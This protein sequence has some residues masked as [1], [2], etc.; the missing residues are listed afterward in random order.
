MEIRAGSPSEAFVEV[1]GLL[2][3]AP[4]V[5]PRALAARELPERL[6]VVVSRPFG[7]VD[8]GPG[9]RLNHAI[10]VVEGLSLVGQCSVPELQ[11]DRVKALS[12]FVN[13]G[14][15]RGA[16]GSRVEGRLTDAVR[17]L[18]RD[19]FSRQAVLSIYDSHRDLGR[20]DD[21]S[22]SGDVPCTVAVQFF[23]RPRVVD[24]YEEALDMWVVMRSNDAWRGL[25]YDLGQFMILHHAMAQALELGVGT[26]THTV[27]SMHLYADDWED[28]ERLLLDAE[29]RSPRTA[30]SAMFGGVGSVASTS[31]RAR[32]ILMG[33]RVEGETYLESWMTDCLDAAED[34]RV[35]ETP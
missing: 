13:D 29:P 15:F 7:F 26:Y 33:R 35:I 22:V 20:W 27:G 9:R 1:L 14:V 11:T 25:P 3:E 23:V 16:Y 6:S 31:Q 34:G 28:A 10:S 2:V 12:H 4:V 21:M 5:S 30:W 17:L 19:P 18:T 24:P 8:V 32:R